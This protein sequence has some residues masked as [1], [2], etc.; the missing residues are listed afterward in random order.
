MADADALLSAV[1][2]VC[3][4]RRAH[5]GPVEITFDEDALHGGRI[6]DHAGKK[7]TAKAFMV[8]LGSGD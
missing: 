4:L 7:Q 3:E 8:G 6:G 2:F 5:D 1:R